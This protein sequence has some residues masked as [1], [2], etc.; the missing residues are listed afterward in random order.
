MVLLLCDVEIWFAMSAFSKSFE[1]N[2]GVGV[3]D[4]STVVLSLREAD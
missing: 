3:M 2:D 1:G 4:V